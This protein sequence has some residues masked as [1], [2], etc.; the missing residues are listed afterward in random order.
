MRQP[1]S[2]LLVGYLGS[3]ILL[4]AALLAGCSATSTSSV[5]LTGS[6]PAGSSPGAVRTPTSRAGASSTPAGSS[7][8]TSQLSCV[9][10]TTVHPI[11]T[12]TETLQCTVAHAASSETAF[13]LR[14][15]VTSNAGPYTNLPFPECKGTLSDG[16][17]SCSVG[18]SAVVPFRLA[19]GTVAGA[20]IPHQ[21]RLGPV[22]PI[23]IAPTPFGSPL[24]FRTPIPPA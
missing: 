21:Y 2:H 8:N 1:S 24:P 23:P 14:F 11:D 4:C 18:I 9:L 13:V 7:S 16:S 19:R 12:V 17:G 5:Q 15:T 3:G 6:H 22:V 10:R 20:T